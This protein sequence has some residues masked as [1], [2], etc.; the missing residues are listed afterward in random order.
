MAIETVRQT[1]ELAP[2][3]TEPEARPTIH[4]EVLMPAHDCWYPPA[5]EMADVLRVDF[6]RKTVGPDGHY[7]IQDATSNWR[8]CRY[9]RRHELTEQLEMDVSGSGEWRSVNN[10][11]DLNIEVVGYVAQV[12]KPAAANTALRSHA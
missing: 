3:A 1:R 9:F 10:L 7:L 2:R 11:E 4:Q 12:Y 6:S 8:G 5:V